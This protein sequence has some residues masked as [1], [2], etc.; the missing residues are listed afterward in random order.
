MPL[1]GTDTTGKVHEALKKLRE[2]GYARRIWK[3]KNGMPDLYLIP[4]SIVSRTSTS[5]GS[6]PLP[7]LPVCIFYVLK[8]S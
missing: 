7:P 1:M 4:E 5:E 8:M 3:S 2:A 6:T